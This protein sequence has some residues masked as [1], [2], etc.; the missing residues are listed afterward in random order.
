MARLTAPHA[1]SICAKSV[2]GVLVRVTRTRW[3]PGPR[4]TFT[5]SLSRRESSA[6]G[7]S[8]TPDQRFTAGET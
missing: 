8:G 7:S 5:N 4:R 6:D 3:L 1:C 2:I